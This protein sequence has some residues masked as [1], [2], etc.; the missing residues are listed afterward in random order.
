LRFHAELQCRFELPRVRPGLDHR[1]AAG[2]RLLVNRQM[3]PKILPFY[4]QRSQ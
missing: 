3:L 2:I 4:R 1:A